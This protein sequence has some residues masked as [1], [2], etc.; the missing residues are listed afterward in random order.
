MNNVGVSYPYPE[1]FLN[2]PNP[3]NV[4]TD[5]L[6]VDMHA[7]FF[8]GRRK[9]WNEVLMHER[10]VTAEFSQEAFTLVGLSMLP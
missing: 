2:I 7:D 4:S 10:L 6:Q 9:S 5:G 1:F 8:H 3:D